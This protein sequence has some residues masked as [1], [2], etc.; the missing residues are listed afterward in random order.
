MFETILGGVLHEC[1]TFSIPVW[2]VFIAVILACWLIYWDKSSSKLKVKGKPFS[3]EA[4]HNSIVIAWEKPLFAD[5]DFYIVHYREVRLE[6]RRWS[7]LK[8]QGNLRKITISD[9]LPNTKYKVKVSACCGTEVG[10]SGEESDDLV[11]KSLAFKIKEASEFVEGSTQGTVSKYAVP[12]R[13]ENDEEMKIQTIKIGDGSQPNAERKSILLI[14]APHSGKTTLIEGIMNYIFGVTFK[15]DFRLCLSQSIKDEVHHEWLKVYHFDE[16]EGGRINLTLTIYDVPRFCSSSMDCENQLLKQIEFVM[17]QVSAE[18]NLICLAIKGNDSHLATEQLE[19]FRSLLS[20]F[21]DHM[22]SNFCALYTFADVGEA[23]I[24]KILRTNEIMPRKSFHLNLSS[25]FQS[26]HRYSQTFWQMNSFQLDSFFDFVRQSSAKGIC[27]KEQL[28]I[29]LQSEITPAELEAFRNDI[30]VASRPTEITPA[31]LEELK[32]D[33]ASLQPQI[34]KDIS[35]MGEIKI[36]IFLFTTRKDEIVSNGDISFTIEE[37]RQIKKDLTPGLHVTN[38]M[39]CY[40][41]CH[42]NCAIPDDDGKRRCSAMD[43]DGNC[44][45]CTSHCIW[46]IHKNTPYIYEYKKEVI[47]KSYQEMKLNYEKEKGKELTYDEYLE[48]LNSDIQALLERLHGKV[49]K[50]AECQNELQGIEHSPIARSVGDT[51]DDLIEAEKRKQERG[52]EKR[53]EMYEELKKYSKMVKI[54]RVQN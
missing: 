48:N 40:Y 13:I 38:C 28:L 9:L 10:P 39:H 43:G 27:K 33:I 47:T 26:S 20:I 15:D 18:I 45:V 16:Y 8:T 23:C 4:T 6:P 54:S 12:S 7:S 32:N 41:T 5:P 49:Q 42:E 34:T 31:K 11:T 25:L 44:M 51:I 3:Q 37:I 2:V 46:S 29:P 17:N 24:H 50:M 36:Q 22:M 30:H 19:Y 1:F 52:Y 21:E 14:S 35:E 53:I